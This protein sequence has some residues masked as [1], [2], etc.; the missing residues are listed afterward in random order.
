MKY[1]GVPRVVQNI[2]DTSFW[3]QFTTNYKPIKKANMLFRISKIQVF[4]SNS[5]LLGGSITDMMSCS[6]YQRYKFLK[7]IHNGVAIGSPEPWVVQNIKDTSFWKQ[8]TTY[9]SPLRRSE[10]LFRISKIQVFESNSQRGCFF[11]VLLN[12]CSE[13]QRYKFL[14]AIH[15]KE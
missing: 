7:A 3:K 1:I 13:Y 8:F 2:K 10:M 14:K 11:F 15:N 12:S 9:A 4:E 5:Q 6:E